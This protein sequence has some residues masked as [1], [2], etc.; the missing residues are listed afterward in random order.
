MVSEIESKD[1]AD[2]KADQAANDGFEDKFN[3]GFKGHGMGLGWFR[4]TWRAQFS[5][6]CRSMRL[7][8][9]HRSPCLSD[10]VLRL[11]LG[12]RE[13]GGTRFASLRL[14]YS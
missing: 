14:R 7:R 9:F 10:V 5:Q 8:E 4:L 3:D 1:G 11:R 13:N 12:G 6:R 2:C